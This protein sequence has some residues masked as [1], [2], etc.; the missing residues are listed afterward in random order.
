MNPELPKFQF[1]FKTW[2][3]TQH[4]VDLLACR[5]LDAKTHGSEETCRVLRLYG[6]PR[7]AAWRRAGASLD[8][9]G[10]RYFKYRP[11]VGTYQPSDRYC[12]VQ[13]GASKESLFLVW[14][15]GAL[16]PQDLRKLF[17][18]RFAGDGGQ[19]WREPD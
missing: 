8:T 10:G 3:V 17:T 11:P 19:P 6:E 5:W 15:N 2:D 18:D 16:L 1:F 13:I 12:T 4:T 9:E 14:R 7:A